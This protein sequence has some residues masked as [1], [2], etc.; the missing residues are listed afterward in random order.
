LGNS[1]Y[2]IKSTTKRLPNIK[3]Q[4][5]TN[6]KDEKALLITTKEML[7]FKMVMAKKQSMLIRML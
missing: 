1:L 7:I 2:K 3:A 4:K 6:N 5:N